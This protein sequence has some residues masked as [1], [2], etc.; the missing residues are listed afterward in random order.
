MRVDFNSPIDP[1]TGRILDDKRLRGHLDS[2]RRLSESSLVLLAHQSRPGKDDFTTLER[3]AERLG[4]L[5]PNERDVGYVDSVFGSSA[6]EEIKRLDKGDVL[7]LE[8]VRFYS[9]EYMSMEPERAAKTHEVERLA[10]LFDAYVNDA[11][12]A[13]HRSQ[14]SLVGFPRRLASYAGDLMEKELRILG[15]VTD[16]EKPRV[17]ALGGGKPVDTVEVTRNVLSKN[18]AERVL[19]S[20]IAGNIFLI[21]QGIE[22]GDETEEFLRDEG[23]YGLVDDAKDILDEFEDCVEIPIDVAVE[24]DGERIEVG[25]DELPAESQA[26]DIGVETMAR[27]SQILR[28]AGTVVVNGPPGVYEKKPF[29]R[30]TEAVFEAASEAGFSVAGGGDTSAAIDAL[31]VKGFD[32]ISSGGGAATSFLSGEK[33]PAVEA[34]CRREEKA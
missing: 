16:S 29:S 28:D 31:D 27:Y 1:A 7:L 26:L 24:R 3:H 12:S 8:N 18:R 17:F 6:R 22:V 11:F 33:L 5:L 9:E 20:G 32:H 25:V 19:I 34:L 15:G 14:P 13:A 21:A 10:P 4:R 30:G 23:H 2:I